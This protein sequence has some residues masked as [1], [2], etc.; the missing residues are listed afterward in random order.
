MQLASQL[1]V[2]CYPCCALLAFSGSRLRLIA[3]MPGPRSPE[4]L[5]AGLRRAVDRHSTQMASE[6]ADHNERVRSSCMCC[7]L[8]GY[9]SE[10]VLVCNAV[11][12]ASMPVPGDSTGTEEAGVIGK[13]QQLCHDC[14][15]HRQTW[16]Q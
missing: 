13:L 15:L 6:Q 16:I 3:L 9:M 4:Q 2:S 7:C 10:A 14:V 11:L 12:L 8:S 1:G 5:L